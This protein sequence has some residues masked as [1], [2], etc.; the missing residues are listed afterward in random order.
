MVAFTVHGGG[1]DTKLSWSIAYVRTRYVV[2]VVPCAPRRAC[3]L[4]Y[5][6]KFRCETFFFF[7]GLVL[8][9][10][11]MS[12]VRGSVFH[13]APMC[14]IVCDCHRTFIVQSLLPSFL[15]S[16]GPS[17]RLAVQQTPGRRFYDD[18]NGE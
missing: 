8:I 18:G 13:S 10:S 6:R 11:S 5:A 12:R 1:G 4:T 3:P 17:D 2:V 15:S 9:S 7:V 14:V 16:A